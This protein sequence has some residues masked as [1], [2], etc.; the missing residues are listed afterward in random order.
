[1]STDYLLRES[2][3]KLKQYIFKE[4]HM[5]FG[6]TVHS[7]SHSLQ[8]TEWELI[9]NSGSYE[10]LKI[11]TRAECWNSKNAWRWECQHPRKRGGERVN[12]LLKFDIDFE[13][14]S[15]RN[16]L[17]HCHGTRY[18]YTYT[19]RYKHTHT[20]TS[21]L[22][23]DT[24]SNTYSH[25]H[26]H[27]L[28]HTHQCENPYPH[29]S[30]N[31]IIIQHTNPSILKPTHN[32]QIPHTHTPTQSQTPNQTQMPKTNPSH[33]PTHKHPTQRKNTINKPIHSHAQTPHPTQLP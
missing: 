8:K 9:E 4:K 30:A 24:P 26:K 5:P 16:G 20:H 22:C 17:A 25:N 1:M 31:T 19:P 23:L 15:Q 13:L 27:Q 3:W 14:F 32:H 6:T 7:F 28:H 29:L 33:A 21:D 2:P 11:V 10:H 18:R 12:K